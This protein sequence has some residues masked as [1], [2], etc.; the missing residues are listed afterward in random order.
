[1]SASDHENDSGTVHGHDLR[2]LQFAEPRLVRQNDERDCPDRHHKRLNDK[3]LLLA[4][5][6]IVADQ[7]VVVSSQSMVVPDQTKIR[8]QDLRHV[9]AKQAVA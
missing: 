2:P 3:V 6:V 1:M 7:R 4:S 5:D 8:Q 9:R